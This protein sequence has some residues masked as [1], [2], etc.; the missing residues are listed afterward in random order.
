MFRKPRLSKT[1]NA[2]IIA[3]IWDK[4][5][6]LVNPDMAASAEAQLCAEIGPQHILFN[7]KEEAVAIA[8]RQDQ[9]DVLYALDDGRFAIVHLTYS[10]KPEPNPNYPDTQIFSAY[11]DFLD[12]A[13][14]PDAAS[15]KLM[16]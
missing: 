8:K 16:D 6:H 3:T 1:L 10:L 4:P 9:D 12:D 11:Q 7:L 14:Y 2:Q 13:L 15:W 5:W